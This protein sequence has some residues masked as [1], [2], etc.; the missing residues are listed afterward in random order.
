MA[1]RS[2]IVLT[3]GARWLGENAMEALL[4]GALAGSVLPPSAESRSGDED[5]AWHSPAPDAD[6]ADIFLDL[7]AVTTIEPYALVMLCALLRHMAENG[8]RPYLLL[9]ESEPVLAVLQRAGLAPTVEAY[10][11]NR[12]RVEVGRWEAEAA[13][14]LVGLASIHDAAD[15][16]RVRCGLSRARAEVEAHLD[17]GPGEGALLEASLVELAQNVWQHSEDWGMVCVGRGVQPRTGRR[18]VTIAVADLGVGMRRSLAQRYEVTDWSDADAIVHATRPGYSRC[19]DQRGI[20]LTQ[21]LAMARRFDGALV[22]RSGGARVHFADRRAHPTAPFPGVQV[23]L[24]L[25]ERRV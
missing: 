5:R 25:R 19:G 13:P 24:T 3:P 12:L 20:G 8:R 23:S 2:Q 21:V 18:S 6:L 9:P 22:I 16:E 7:R 11:G 17:L 1:I 4:E 14:V 10:S 15:V